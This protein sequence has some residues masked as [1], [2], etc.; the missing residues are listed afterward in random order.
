MQSIQSIQSTRFA[1]STRPRRASP[2]P[3][4]ELA[5]NAALVLIG[6]AMSLLDRQIGAQA[7][8]FEEDGGFTERLCRTRT[9]RRQRDAGRRPFKQ[10]GGNGA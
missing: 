5:A 10:V 3:Y 6:V 7:R 8:A 1:P 2:P 9:A 4:S